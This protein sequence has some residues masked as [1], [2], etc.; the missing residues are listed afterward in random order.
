MSRNCSA[1]ANTATRPRRLACCDGGR[2]ERGRWLPRLHWRS[3]CS[4]CGS[5]LNFC[6]F[7]SE[8]VVRLPAI[9]QNARDTFI[10]SA[11]SLEPGRDLHDFDV[12]ADRALASEAHAGRLPRPLRAVSVSIDRALRPDQPK[13]SGKSPTFFNDACV[14]PDAVARQS[15]EPARAQAQPGDAMTAQID[16]RPAAIRVVIP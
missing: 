4:A 15:T 12:F 10:S 5:G 11:S 16:K 14:R 2:M 9:L 1:I 8:R 13:F 3:R 6:I 7:S